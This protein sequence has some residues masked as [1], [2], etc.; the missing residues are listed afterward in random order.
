VIRP[1][2]ESTG[3]ADKAVVPS[4]RVVARTLFLRQPPFILPKLNAELALDEQNFR[5]LI[6]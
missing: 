2:Y 1:I 4:R 6:K 5:V 3:L